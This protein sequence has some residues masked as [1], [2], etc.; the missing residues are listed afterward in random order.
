MR[1]NV[2]FRRQANVLGGQTGVPGQAQLDQGIAV[3]RSAMTDAPVECIEQRFGLL[4]DLDVGED[5]HHAMGLG[6]GRE[7][8]ARRAPAQSRT[9]PAGVVRQ[10]RT[11]RSA[12]WSWSITTGHRR[13]RLPTQPVTRWPSFLGWRCA[14]SPTSTPP[15]NAPSARESAIP[16]CWRSC[17]AP[18]A[19]RHPQSQPPQTVL[20]RLADSL[21]P[22]CSNANRSPPQAEKILDAHLLPGP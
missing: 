21:N 1:R 10:A 15:W 7:A 17:P 13:S 5:A 6:P 9:K 2:H 22:S 16:R 14:L 12:V 18:A 19:H 11:A 8:V 20:P 4:L 3:A